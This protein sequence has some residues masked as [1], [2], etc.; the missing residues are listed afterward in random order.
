MIQHRA[1]RTV[2]VAGVAAS[3]AAAAAGVVY[4]ITEGRPGNPDP[5]NHRLH[6]LAADPVFGV[7]PPGATRTGRQETPAHRDPQGSVFDGSGAGWYGPSVILSFTSRQP[8]RDVYRFYEEQAA[9][10]GWAPGER[11]WAGF[12]LT[13]RKSIGGKPAN[14]NLQP[15]FDLHAVDLTASGTPRSYTFSGS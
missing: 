6:A 10:A 15:D 4:S 5:G 12:P 9:K 7:L 8:V 2:L 11:I 3:L 1:R 14:L 13:W